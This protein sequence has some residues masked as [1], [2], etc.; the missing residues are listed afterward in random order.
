MGAWPNNALH[1][2]ASSRDPGYPEP[3]SQ[4]RTSAI[5]IRLF[6]TVGYTPYGRPVD[7]LPLS[8]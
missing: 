3:L 6:G 2:T 8:Q 5:H 7:D 1:L 4:N